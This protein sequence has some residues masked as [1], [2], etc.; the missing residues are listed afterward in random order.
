VS[1]APAEMLFVRTNNKHTVRPKVMKN[2]AEMIPA[3][4]FCLPM[5]FFSMVSNLSLICFLL[6]VSILTTGF[7]RKSNLRI[8]VKGIYKII[9]TACNKLLIFKKNILPGDG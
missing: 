3:G 6:I 5:N 7:V 8:Y 4:D 1:A 9:I 2:L